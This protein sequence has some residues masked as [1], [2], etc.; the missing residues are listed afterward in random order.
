M[1]RMVFNGILF[2]VD[3]FQTEGGCLHRNLC[4]DNITA[5]TFVDEIISGRDLMRVSRHFITNSV[6]RDSERAEPQRR[7]I[8]S[9]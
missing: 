2:P 3:A 4:T 7:S 9:E 1:V 6:N 5:A 8:K